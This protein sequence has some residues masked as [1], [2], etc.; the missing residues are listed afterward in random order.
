MHDEHK[1]KLSTTPIM[2]TCIAL[3][4][5]DLREVLNELHTVRDKWMIIGLQLGVE[6]S[7]LQD[8]EKQPEGDDPNR[9]KRL[10]SVLLH[11]IEVHSITWKDICEALSSPSV[12]EQV[13]AQQLAKA[14][15]TF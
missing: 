14:K 4:R 2:L 9:N 8:I 7:V 10:L 3:T 11:A 1:Y 15:G 13:L 5:K 12:G 6:Y